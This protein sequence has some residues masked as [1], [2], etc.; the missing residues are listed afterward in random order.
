MSLREKRMAE[1]ERNFRFYEEN[2]AGLDE[3]LHGKYAL[4]RRE[5]FVEFF[6]SILDAHTSAQ[7]RF[8]DGLYSIQQ[9]AQKPV[10][11]GFYSHADGHPQT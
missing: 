11:L 5:R 2:L 8:A 7:E 3:S 6:N 1:V 10:D 4:L 9:V